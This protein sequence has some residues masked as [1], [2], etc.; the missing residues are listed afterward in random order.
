MQ[1]KGLLPREGKIILYGGSGGGFLVQQYLDR[2][3]FHISRALIESSGAPDLAR[4]HNV[5]FASNLYELNPEAANV[6]FSAL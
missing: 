1:D 2:Y 3:G 6:Y 4:Q 5:T